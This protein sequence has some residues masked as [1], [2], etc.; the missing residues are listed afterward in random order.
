MF[1]YLEHRAMW[2]ETRVAGNKYMQWGGI[3][4][5][6]AKG[7]CVY[8]LEQAQ[9]Q[10]ILAKRFSNLW[11]VALDQQTPM[12]VSAGNSKGSDRTAAVRDLGN[13]LEGAEDGSDEERRNEIEDDEESM[14]DNEFPGND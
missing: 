12:T 14:E 7:I 6:L 11:A 10:H 13:E 1:M 9:Q 8:A 5:A 4:T 3:S 2:W